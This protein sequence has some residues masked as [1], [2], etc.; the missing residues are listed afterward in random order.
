MEGSNSSNSRV[1]TNNQQ[2]VSTNLKESKKN[3]D[4][5]NMLILNGNDVFEKE[6]CKEKSHI[7]KEKQ[8]KCCIVY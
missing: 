7:K 4:E 1:N 2:N 3:S 5:K 8:I 6:N